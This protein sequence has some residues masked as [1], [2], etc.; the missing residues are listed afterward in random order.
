MSDA[1]IADWAAADEA[2]PAVS[3]NAKTRGDVNFISRT[4][5][6]PVEQDCN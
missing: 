5:R 2:E 6:P 1:V 4:M 3:A